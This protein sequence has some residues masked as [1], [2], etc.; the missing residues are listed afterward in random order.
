[1]DNTPS[2]PLPNL[3]LMQKNI[4]LHHVNFH[5]S[6]DR[7][8]LFDVDVVFKMV[9]MTGE[10]S[11]IVGPSGCGKSTLLGCL[12]QLHPV[13]SGRVMIDGVDLKQFSSRSVRDQL[14]VVFQQGGVLNGT[15]MDNIRYGQPTATDDDCKRAAKSAECHNFIEQLK[16]GYDTVVGQHALVN[17]SG[18]QL[19]R[20]CL[21]RALVREPR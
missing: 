12:M 20:I 5:Y 3:H 18:G 1:M 8:I 7:Q 17:L 16:D 11:C 19:Q 2:T 10:Y 14:A 13:S 6:T 15:I 9:F 4:A 21:A